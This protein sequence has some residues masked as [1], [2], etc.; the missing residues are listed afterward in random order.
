M[1]ALLEGEEGNNIESF[2]KNVGVKD[3]RPEEMIREWIIPQ[4]S[5]SNK[6]S[7]EQNRLHVRYLLH[8]HYFLFWR[9]DSSTERKRLIEKISETPILRAYRSVQREDYDFVAPCNAY[10]PQAYT[11]N[12]DL[13]TYFSVCDDVRF[14]DDRYLESDSEPGS[15]L[16]FLKGIGA[17]D[18]PRFFKQHPYTYDDDLELRNI[19]REKNTGEET[20]EE[21]YFDG[22]F[23]VLDEISSGRKESNLSQVLWHLLVKALPPEQ[24]NRD[25]HFRGTYHWFYYRCKQKPFDADFYLV[26][27]KDYA[28]LLDKQGK[29]R[30]PSECFAP[31][32]E[33]CRVLGDSVAYLHPDFDISEDNEPARWLAEKLGIHLNADTESVLNYLQTLSGHNSER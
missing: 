2:L 17:T 3:L 27:K 11:G 8:V 21:Y 22:V 16:R 4:Y 7:V 26:L 14:V 15:W 9:K 12:A 32:P 13:E 25:A 28:W 29:S 24:G 18:V 20:I 30:Y 1:A 5:Q 33:N 6:P 19:K 31:T 10:L 23:N